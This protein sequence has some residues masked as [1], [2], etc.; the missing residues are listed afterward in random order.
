VPLVKPLPPTVIRSVNPM[1]DSWCAFIKH[2]LVLL[3]VMQGYKSY[4]FLVDD[5]LAPEVQCQFDGGAIVSVTFGRTNDIVVEVMSAD[6]KPVFLT[7]ILL[8][9]LFGRNALT[10]SRLLSQR[11]SGYLL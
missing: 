3:A 10:M 4:E 9:H 2:S 7:R 1:G 11:L 6:G 8:K 5:S